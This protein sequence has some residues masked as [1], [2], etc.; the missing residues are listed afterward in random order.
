MVNFME[1]ESIFGKMEISIKDNG[2][3]VLE[4]EKELIAITMEI[5]CI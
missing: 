4:M 2:K 3:M 5:L 1:M